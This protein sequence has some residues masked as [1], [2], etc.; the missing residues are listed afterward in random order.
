MDQALPVLVTSAVSFIHLPG[1]TLTLCRWEHLDLCIGGCSD[2][3]LEKWRLFT[4]VRVF[5]CSAVLALC[6]YSYLGQASRE[7]PAGRE[8]ESA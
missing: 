6:A 1:H 7:G 4:L 2:L 3:E 5:V 8:P